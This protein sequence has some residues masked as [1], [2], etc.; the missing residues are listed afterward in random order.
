MLYITLGIHTEL[1]FADLQPIPEYVF[2][3]F[4]C[5]EQALD[6][7]LKGKNPYAKKFIGTSF[8]Y[9]PPAFFIIEFF[10][11]FDPLLFKIS[12]FSACNLA[13]MI[14]LVFGI[15]R[16]Y[17]CPGGDVWY[18]YVLCLASAPF[19]EMLHVGQINLIVMFGIFLMFVWA[20]T[21]PLLSGAGLG[22]AIV[23]KVSP[24]LFFCDLLINR[25]FRI[26]AGC[27]SAILVLF[28]ASASRYGIE[29]VI[30][31]P[32]RLLLLTQQFPVDIQTNNSQSLVAVLSAADSAPFRENLAAV[33][34]DLLNLVCS[35]GR[36]AASHQ[37]LVQICLLL[38]ILAVIIASALITACCGQPREPS[39]II[40]ALGMALSPNI[41]WYHHYVFILLPLLVWMGWRRRNRRILAWC[42]LGLLIIQMD[43]K[44]LTCGLLIH[45]FGHV[46]LLT[47]LWGQLCSLRWRTLTVTPPSAV[48]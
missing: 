39:F 24:A 15:S 45:A 27:I 21:I 34:D 47:I 2:K 18:W 31:Y 3:D 33:P 42:L 25:R 10:H 17:R 44:F 14:A 11:F 37:E 40:S 1:R 26:L 8:L 29:P 19:F 41:M 20:D 30:E 9:P 32:K 16:H 4:S 28:L 38:Y 12:F 43:R 36:F 35:A 23:S 13:L 5:Y 48:Q 22:L 7:A 46:S 6:Q